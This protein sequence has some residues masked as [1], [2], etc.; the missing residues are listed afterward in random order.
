MLSL[1]TSLSAIPPSG[2]GPGGCRVLW[3]GY[4][5]REEGKRSAEPSLLV[6]VGAISWDPQGQGG[7]QLGLRWWSL[8]E[9]MSLA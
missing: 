8:P 1:P 4:E 9:G 6:P 3:M 2:P 5:W 7:A